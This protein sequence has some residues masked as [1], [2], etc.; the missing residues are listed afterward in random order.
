M[1]KRSEDLREP[2]TR[3][4][5]EKGI[6]SKGWQR[7]VYSLPKDGHDFAA[8]LLA[9]QFLRRKKRIDALRV[10]V[11]RNAHSITMGSDHQ[12]PS[13]SGALASS[14]GLN[15]AGAQGEAA[16]GVPIA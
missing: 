6:S 1:R 16:A 10:A 11:D 9:V 15:V 8:S 7:S 2:E 14:W 13:S 4:V 12:A 5:L 3:E